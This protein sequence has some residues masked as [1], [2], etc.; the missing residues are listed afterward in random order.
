MKLKD[1]ALLTEIVGGVGILISLVVL[2]LEVRQNTALVER[3]ILLDRSN[4][5]AQ[6]IDSPYIAPIFAK[7]KAIDDDIV[8][9]ERA[10]MRQYDLTFEEATRFT[11]WLRREWNG[12]QAEFELGTPGLDSVIKDMLQH[13]DQNLFWTTT[14]S[15]YAADFVN[16]V[17]DLNE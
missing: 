17:D 5:V 4:W 7:I 10:F 11:T 14:R 15:Q 13:K 9:T 3:Q 12:Y 2:V 8:P 1:I 6:I 16:F